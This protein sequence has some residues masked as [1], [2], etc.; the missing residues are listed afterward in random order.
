MAKGLNTNVFYWKQGSKYVIICNKY[1]NTSNY[2][3]KPKRTSQR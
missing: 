2:Q 3:P 1:W